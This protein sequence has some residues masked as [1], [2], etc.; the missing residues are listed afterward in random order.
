MLSGVTKKLI[1][2]LLIGIFIFSGFEIVKLFAEYRQ[3]EEKYNK[4]AEEFVDEEII[5]KK[6]PVK[7]EAPIKVDFANLTPLNQDI[8]GWIWI[9]DSSINYPLVQGNDNQKYLNYMYDG[10]YNKLGSIFMDYR[11]TSNLSGNHTVIYGHNMLTDD[12]FGTLEKYKD[13]DYYSLHKYIY[14]IGD[15]FVKKYEIF[16]SYITDAYGETYRVKFDDE[17]SYY[18]YLQKMKDQSIYDTGVIIEKED[19]I[20][21]LSTCT[22]SNNKNERFV[23]QAKEIFK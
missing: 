19:K 3:G 2:I 5:E 11:C 21:T 10:S 4:A 6:E 20:I 14:I 16:S 12:M 9:N 7:I 23:V 8:R 18:E 22:S 17:N 1:I 15:E 13:Y